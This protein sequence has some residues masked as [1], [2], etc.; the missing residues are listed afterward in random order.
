MG[1]FPVTRAL[2]MPIIAYASGKF[3][4]G[5]VLMQPNYSSLHE[6]R[7][8]HRVKADILNPR[9]FISDRN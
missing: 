6:H 2:N 4:T 5:W 8:K 7:K 3:S 9:L 1:G